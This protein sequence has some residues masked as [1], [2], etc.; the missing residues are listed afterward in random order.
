MREL[1]IFTMPEEAY[2]ELRHDAGVTF[3][4]ESGTADGRPAHILQI[5]GVPDGHGATLIVTADGYVP[6]EQ[7]GVLWVTRPGPRAEFAVDDIHL[8]PF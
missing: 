8:R 5:D 7:R 1:A 2:V 6:V 3:R 4:S